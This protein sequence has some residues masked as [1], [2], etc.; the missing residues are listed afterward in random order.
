MHSDRL[1]N[2]D[3]VD[4]S[5]DLPDLLGRSAYAKDLAAVLDRVSRHESSSVLALIGP[6]GSGKSSLIAMTRR[7]LIERQAPREWLM[8]EYNPWSYTDVDTLIAG[9]FA[10]I[11]D[12]LPE[13]G[14]WSETRDKIR[15][16][17]KS[18]KPYA[19]LI[20]GVNGEAVEAAA[21][22]IAGNASMAKKRDAVAHALKELN[23]PILV[24]LDDLD[25]L[26]PKELLLVFKLVRLVGRLPNLY[27]LLSYDEQTLLDV[28][29]R[30]DLVSDQI[31]RARDYL[32]KIAQVRLDLPAF[33]EKQKGEL[34]D[35]M[36]DAILGRHGTLTEEEQYLLGRA[37]YD[38]IGYRLSTPR[39]VNRFMA[40]L[41]ALYGP[42]GEEVSFFDFFVITF[43]RT[44]ESGVYAMLQRY[45]DDLLNNNNRALL[46]GGASQTPA[47]RLA[48]WQ[49]R[50]EVAGVARDNMSGVMSLLSALFVPIQSAHD[51][52]SFGGRDF[53]ELG[54]QRG[55]GHV[56]YFDR[57]FTFGVPEEDI[58]DRTV[59]VALQQLVSERAGSELGM[60]IDRLVT[61]TGRVIRKLDSLREQGGLPS[62]GVL[63]LLADK[64]GDL[65]DDHRLFEDPRRMFIYLAMNLFRD[66]NADQGEL[67]I[68]AMSIKDSGLLFTA[69]A[70]TRFPA[71]VSD[72]N[73]SQDGQE[74]QLAWL[75]Q[76]RDVVRGLIVERL[77]SY[78]EPHDRDRLELFFSLHAAW[79]ILAP[80][81]ARAWLL[82]QVELEKVSLQ[83]AV[84]SLVTVSYGG[85][86]KPRHR[87][88]SL[89]P[90]S[91]DNALGIEFV[92]HRLENEIDAA[93][94]TATRY[95]GLEPSPE[96]RRTFA[97]AELN[98]IRDG[99]RAKPVD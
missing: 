35:D 90:A 46:G 38:H 73:T 60:L 80:E 96:G 29:M 5:D 28:L 91:V 79:R 37:Y 8:A 72:G 94:M 88:D 58:A 92:L 99:R 50:L 81:Q 31:S 23:R 76:A 15:E 44:F 69:I 78:G 2:D 70:I 40:Q 24:I 48:I 26:E 95:S 11:R 4:G 68:R 51:N 1:F 12:A 82:Q 93:D 75:S 25:R 89:D 22:T 33:R 39:A 83:D 66:L 32:E 43:L 20:P 16:F 47:Q 56:D 3:P 27:Y 13:D 87:M 52:L 14:R 57:Y 10:E 49:E 42:A 64:Y 19:G 85:S 7:S 67:V 98:R 77:A 54:K 53:G 45:K 55:V 21:N 86:T 17:G 41:D 63:Q 30:T 6:W 9:F 97:L 71:A 62:A 65:P 59:L 36:L 84:G 34:V 74:R 18:I 61:D